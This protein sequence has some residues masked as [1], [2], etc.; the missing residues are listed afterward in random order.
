MVSFPITTK[1][2]LDMYK[3]VICNKH[4]N[5][6]NALDTR[7]CLQAL[8]ENQ[9]II[10]IY[11]PRTIIILTCTD[12]H[13]PQGLLQSYIISLPVPS[14]HCSFLAWWYKSVIIFIKCLLIVTCDLLFPK[15]KTFE[16]SYQLYTQTF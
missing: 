9:R 16:G 6:I 15:L 12:V 3:N 5:N 1:F 7:S 8:G 11:L 14:F 10:P 2:I 4:F 13:T